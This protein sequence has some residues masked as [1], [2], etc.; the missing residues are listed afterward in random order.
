[1]SHVITLGSGL[2]SAQ[3]DLA[4]KMEMRS[5]VDGIPLDDF[6]MSTKRLR[7]KKDD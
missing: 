2:I 7:D 5:T 6:D 1:M 4:T 3:N